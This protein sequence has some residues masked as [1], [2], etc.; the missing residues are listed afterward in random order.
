MAAIVYALCSIASALCAVLLLRQHARQRSR[1]LFWS[2][3]S[4]VG[5]AVSN[6]LVFVDFVVWPDIDLSLLRV[7]T[8]FISVAVL[9]YGLLWEAD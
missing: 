1:L 3:L 4:F 5:F 6:A 7:A 9:L 8:G 2:G